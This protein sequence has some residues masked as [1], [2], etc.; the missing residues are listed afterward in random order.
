MTENNPGYAKRVASVEDRSLT[1]NGTYVS[2]VF[3]LGAY[4]R[5]VGSLKCDK[6]VTVKVYQGPSEASP[7]H[8]A[9]TWTSTGNADFGAGDGYAHLI[10]VPEGYGQI[11][12]S[13]TSGS[14]ATFSLTIGLTRA[15]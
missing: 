14:T 12:I 3:P 7:G 9:E 11:R 1:N 4:A 6:V 2:E 10:R 15:H 13:N 8:F 5:I